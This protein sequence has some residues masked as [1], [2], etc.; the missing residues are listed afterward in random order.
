MQI[1]NKMKIIL[2]SKHPIKLFLSY[3]LRKSRVS[4][5]FSIDR[6][7]YKLKF[8]PS[9]ILMHYWA[10]TLPNKEFEIIFLN[11]LLKVG[12]TVLDIGSNVGS[13]SI[14]LAC[15]VGKN[16]SIISVEA[17]PVIYS[18]LCGNV[19]FNNLVN[20]KTINSAIGN[21]E[22]RVE[23]SN[24]SSDDMN[25]VIIQ[26]K[27]NN[28]TFE[29]K[30]TTIDKLLE[31]EKINSIRLLK[32]DIE[33]FE[34]FALQGAINTLRKTEIIYIESF[35]KHFNAYGY[36]TVDLIVLLKESSFSVF[37]YEND[38]LVELDNNYISYSCENLIAFK[39]QS[40]IENLFENNSILYKKN[41]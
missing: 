18:Y 13:L 14:P 4:S 7:Y 33:G 30:I 25:K 36:S 10:G 12:S 6:G 31:N 5:I 39:D 3:I 38:I 21:E 11:K 2:T 8:Y 32:I 34:L 20:I 17:N 19:K 27:I 40:E 24:I 15:Q 9:A 22:G 29:V 1:I 41:L 35:E 28:N 16:G 23:F 37:K 26:D